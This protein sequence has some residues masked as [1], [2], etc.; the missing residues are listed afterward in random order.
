MLTSLEL[1]VGFSVILT[2][3]AKERDGYTII[4]RGFTSPEQERT[5]TT[6]TQRHRENIDKDYV[7][8]IFICLFSVSLCLCGELQRA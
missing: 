1:V 6:E 5:F 7:V 2:T 4:D 3:H 8:L